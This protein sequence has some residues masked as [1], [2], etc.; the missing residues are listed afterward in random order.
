MA[1]RF[2]SDQIADLAQILGGKT[3]EAIS[4]LMDDT[5]SHYY[6][7]GYDCTDEPVTVKISID[8]LEA[9]SDFG[10]LHEL[11]AIRE[12]M[13]CTKQDYIVLYGRAAV[14]EVTA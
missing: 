7:Y 13:R 12:C 1:F 2:S 14:K 5:I 11:N 6:I 9:V 3:G 10:H 8:T 4:N